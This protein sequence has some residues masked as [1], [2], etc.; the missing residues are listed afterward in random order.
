MYLFYLLFPLMMFCVYLFAVFHIFSF[1]YQALFILYLIFTFSHFPLH[2]LRGLNFVCCLSVYL[3]IHCMYYWSWN[4]F[5]I[6]VSYRNVCHCIGWL[7]FRFGVSNYFVLKSSFRLR[8]QCVFLVQEYSWVGLQI[9]F[10]RWAQRR[11]QPARA[12]VTVLDTDHLQYEA[13]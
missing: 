5:R 1:L 6:A 7:H 2:L 10:L 8:V 3:C 4:I 9:Y 13:V 11:L 12:D